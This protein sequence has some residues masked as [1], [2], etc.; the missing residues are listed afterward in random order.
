MKPLD[1][2]KKFRQ[3]IKDAVRGTN[4][5]PSIVMAHALYEA[6]DDD[7]NVG[8]SVHAAS[9]NNDVRVRAGASWKGPKVL[10][11]VRIASGTLKRKR[12]AWFRVYTSAEDSIGDRI[13]LLTQKLSGR[14]LPFLYGRTLKMQALVLQQSITRS[15]PHY[16]E[17]MVNLIVK[18]KLYWYDRS[19]LIEKACIV[20]LTIATINAV[21]YLLETYWDQLVPWR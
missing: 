19:W 16:A 2:I 6:A 12:K 13:R 7:G 4:L 11:P 3:F 1:Y 21:R 18:H 9:Y 8:K 15:D 14:Q 17:R 5:L 10:L 20:A